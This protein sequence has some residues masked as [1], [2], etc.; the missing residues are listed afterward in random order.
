MLTIEN[1]SADR[2]IA[3]DQSTKDILKKGYFG[4]SERNTLILSKEEA[5]YL[6]ELRNA[7]CRKA[8]KSIAFNEAASRFWKNRKFMARYLTYKDWRDRGLI[9]K[10]PDFKYLKRAKARMKEYPRAAFK[11]NVKGLKGT[12]FKTDLITIIEDPQKGKKLYDNFWIGQYGSYKASERGKLNKVDIYEALFLTEKNALRIDNATKATLVKNGNISR[13]DFLKLYSVYKDWREKGYVI[14]TGFKFGTHF[15]V[16][17]PGAKPMGTSSGWTHSKHVI[18]V[19]PKDAKMLISEWAR[20][21]RVAHSVRKTF[22]LAIPGSTRTN[23]MD[24]DY[25]LYH[26]RNG[27]AENPSNGAPRY[28]M[29]SL[30]EDEHIGGSEI[31]GAIKSAGRKGLELVLAIADR[32]TA[33]TYYKVRQI[34][35]KGSKNDYYEIDWMQP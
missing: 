31:S 13:K 14:K 15:R 23:R 16:Y 28:A 4:R 30:G 21:I 1:P 19:F 22:I 11:L 24:I 3:T 26:R 34:S 12:F 6:M 27:E 25:I 2:F 29:L 18:H 35:L 8:G 9:I 17:F 33:V 32:E 20:A 10:D 5:I 7:E